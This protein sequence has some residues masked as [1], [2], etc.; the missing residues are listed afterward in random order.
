MRTNDSEEAAGQTD[1]PE[2]LVRVTAG[3]AQALV[4]HYTETAETPAVPVKA[5]FLDLLQLAAMNELVAENPSL[6]GFRVYF[7]L[8]SNGAGVGVVVGV[9]ARNT[10]LSTQ[11]IYKTLSVNSGPCPPNCDRESPIVT[12]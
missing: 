2:G 11:G 5:V 7:G 10:D 4:K 3:E 9:D 8:E 12:E 1:L 6:A